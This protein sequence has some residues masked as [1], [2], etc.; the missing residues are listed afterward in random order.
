MS[1]E[2]GAEARPGTYRVVVWVRAD[3]QPEQ[4]LTITVKVWPVTL[5][6]RPELRTSFQFTP[7]LL[8]PLYQI[9]DPAERQAMTI[10]YW[11]FLH[12]HKIQPDQIYTVDGDPTPKPPGEKFVPQPVDRITYIRDHYG[13]TQFTAMYLWAGLLDPAKPETWDAQIDTWIG[14]LEVAMA[15][16]EAAGVAENAVVYGF[17][18]STGPMLQAAKY[19]FARVKE[20]FPDLPIMTTLRDDTFGA[21]TGLTEVVDIWVPWIDGYRK[22]VAEA[23]RAEGERIW[24][25]HAISTN[26]PQPNWFNGYPPIDARMLM[27][28][29]SHQANVEGILYY[30]TNRWPLGDRGDQLLVDDGILS[31][32]N[33]ATYFGTAGDGSIFYPGPDGPMASLRLENVRDGLE[34]YNLMQE[35]KRALAAHPDA[36]A[37]IREQAEAALG[38]TAVVTDSRH[39]T[40][41]PTEY[42]TWRA[43][44][45]RLITL[46]AGG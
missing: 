34:D 41:D 3:G 43:D 8:W 21:A 25:Y 29:M 39:F 26:Y 33:P 18:E 24:W 17:D 6:D 13:L 28:P 36:P 32:W 1:V 9:T 10:K 5:R 40:E 37:G 11:D 4:R 45:A 12:E 38:A 35:L 22:D 27:G 30:A 46:L 2:S 20:R 7:W 23:A 31:A 42:R 14:Q 15:D 19:T 44:V 16:Y